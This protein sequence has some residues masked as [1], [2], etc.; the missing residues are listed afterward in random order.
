MFVTL[1]M[2]P[3]GAGWYRNKSTRKYSESE[4]VQRCCEDQE[5]SRQNHLFE[6]Q[7]HLKWQ[8][9]NRWGSQSKPVKPSPAGGLNVQI[10]IRNRVVCTWLLNGFLRWPLQVKTGLNS[11]SFYWGSRLSSLCHMLSASSARGYIGP[12]DTLHSRVRHL[13]TTRGLYQARIDHR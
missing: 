3:P 11:R 7:N 1:S 6:I 9:A 8:R 2:T 5:A 10:S 13:S 4:S 12:T